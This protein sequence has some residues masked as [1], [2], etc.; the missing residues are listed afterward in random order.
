M[1][2]ALRDLTIAVKIMA[3]FKEIVAFPKYFS[4]KLALK[5]MFEF[6]L[7]TNLCRVHIIYIHIG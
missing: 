6:V 5:T 1:N 7:N 3:F 4:E 2:F